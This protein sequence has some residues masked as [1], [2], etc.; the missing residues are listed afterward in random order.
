MFGLNKLVTYSGKI[1]RCWFYHVSSIT[2]WTQCLKKECPPQALCIPA[3]Q[4]NWEILKL[5]KTNP[6][7]FLVFV[8]FLGIKRSLA[9]FIF[10]KKG[11]KGILKVFCNSSRALWSSFCSFTFYCFRW[12]YDNFDVMV[13]LLALFF[14]SWNT[15]CP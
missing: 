9:I 11:I 2:I 3:F 12:F 8:N 10:K 4:R 5:I 13:E 14:F 1:P 7:T 6:F 15:G